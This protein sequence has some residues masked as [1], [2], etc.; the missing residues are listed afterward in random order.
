MYICSHLAT[1]CSQVVACFFIFI[2]LCKFSSTCGIVVILSQRGHLLQRVFL[3]ATNNATRFSC[4]ALPFFLF[5]SPTLNFTP[6]LH[7][8]QT[9]LVIFAH[10][11]AFYGHC[12]TNYLVFRRINFS[13]TVAVLGNK[14]Q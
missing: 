13:I 7:T 2:F 3:V 12:Y 11:F 4:C 10:S 1:R 9:F 14:Q 5:R 8:F 6:L